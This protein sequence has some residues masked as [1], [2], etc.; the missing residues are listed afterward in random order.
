VLHE[1][2]ESLGVSIVTGYGQDDRAVGVRVP[3][4][5]R[6]FSS[7]QT[8]TDSEAHPAFYP[9]GTEGIFPGGKAAGA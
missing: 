9:M 3:V 5:S 8:L 6:I 1:Y 4:G 7:R 2:C